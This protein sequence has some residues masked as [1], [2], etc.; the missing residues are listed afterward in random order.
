MPTGSPENITV[1]A[2]AFPS[3]TV[4]ITWNPPLLKDRNG[5]IVGYTIKLIR[6]MHNKRDSGQITSIRTDQATNATLTRL[7]A[8]TNYQ[9]TITAS[10]AIGIGPYSLPISYKTHD[11]GI[12][13]HKIS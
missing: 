10:T 2:G 9:I 3:S 6:L 13:T 5:I 4:K 11:S 1:T 8:S 7:N 12:I